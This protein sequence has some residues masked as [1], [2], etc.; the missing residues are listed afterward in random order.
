MAKVEVI[1][2]TS[3]VRELLKSKEMMGICEEYANR[4][5]NSLPAGYEISTLDG[6]NRVNAQISAVSF[7]AK[8][9]NAKNNTL[10]KALGALK[11]G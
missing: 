4:A 1:L 11:N 3:G 8:R 5:L 10:L 9:D 6:K 2:N 7:G